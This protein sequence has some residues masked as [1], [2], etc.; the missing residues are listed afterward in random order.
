[1]C[2]YWVCG[3]CSTFY[4]WLIVDISEVEGQHL[5]TSYHVFLQPSLAQKKLV[6]MNQYTEIL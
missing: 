6:F 5:T 1:M 2:S 3:H 4:F